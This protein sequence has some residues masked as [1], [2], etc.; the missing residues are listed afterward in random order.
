[1]DS[2]GDTIRV[3]SYSTRQADACARTVLK[4]SDEV[5]SWLEGYK[6][7][8]RQ[9]M[10]IAA[11]AKSNSPDYETARALVSKRLSR[12]R[13]SITRLATANSNLHAAI[14]HATEA[15]EGQ[16]TDWMNIYSLT[17]QQCV[18]LRNRGF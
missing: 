11:T 17:S 9:L 10:L 7:A 12:V 2:S 1:M 16:V 18:Q 5:A 14:H 15:S 6:E 8:E 4:Y 3:S 13:L